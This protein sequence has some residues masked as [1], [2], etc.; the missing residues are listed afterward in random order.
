MDNTGFGAYGLMGTSENPEIMKIKNQLQDSGA[1][2][3]SL[4]GS[5]S[6]M[7]GVYDNL[8]SVKN[9]RDLFNDFQTYIALPIN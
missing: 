3:T 4:S 9:A 1:L 2:F 7:F 5:G 6:T 8:E